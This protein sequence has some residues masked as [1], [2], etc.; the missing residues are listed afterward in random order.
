MNVNTLGMGALV[1]G[2]KY[3]AAQFEVGAQK[4]IWYRAS[5]THQ[6]DV[7]IKAAHGLYSRCMDSK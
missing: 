3:G 7:H 1:I 4:Y 6:N 2:E 5:S